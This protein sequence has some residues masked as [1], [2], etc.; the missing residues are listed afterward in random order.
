MVSGFSRGTSPERTRSDIVIPDSRLTDLHRMARPKLLC[1]MD[2]LNAGVF[3]GGLHKRGLMSNDDKN[4]LRRNNLAR[5]R[6]HMP[7]TALCRQSHAGPSD[8]ST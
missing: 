7:Q 4:I 8:V 6:N 3:H 2:E 1:L 5:A